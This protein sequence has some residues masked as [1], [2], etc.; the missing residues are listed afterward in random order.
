MR[1]HMILL[2]A[3]LAC[4]ANYALADVTYVLT[5]NTSSISGTT[6]S[7]DFNFNPGPLVTQAASLQILNFSTNGALVGA[8]SLLGDVSGT[9]PGTLTFDNGTA[10]NDY[11]QGFT[12]GSSL[13]FDAKFYG[14]AVNSPDGTSTSGT[15]FAFSMFS[16]PAGTMPVL[17]TD[18]VNG[19]AYVVEINLDGSTTATNFLPGNAVPEPGTASFI[20]AVLL[21]G[22]ASATL[23]KH[24]RLGSPPSRLR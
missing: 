3:L 5:V 17:T 19:F 20:L 16:D 13:S 2:G 9:L 14:P 11:F 21:F 6:G 1:K 8:P 10:F 22:I 24:R 7:L 12:F 4:S 23:R 15:A 18:T